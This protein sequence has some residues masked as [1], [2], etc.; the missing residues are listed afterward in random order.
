MRKTLLT[1]A[2]GSALG[3]PALAQAQA[4]SP[5]SFSANVGLYSEYVF[6]GIKQTAGEPALDST[7]RTRAASTSALG[8]RT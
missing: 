8:R 5:H 7:M 6:R 1:L 4:Q 3:V 2:L